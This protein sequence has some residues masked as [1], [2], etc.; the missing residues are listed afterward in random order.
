MTTAQTGPLSASDALDGAQF[1]PGAV[2]AGR[3]RIVGL[4][5]H[6]G[7]GDVYRADDLKLGQA[8]ALK[9]LPIELTSRPDR[10]A[11]FHT[12]VRLARQVSHPNVC[13]VHDIGDFS[14]QHFLSMEYI[15][16]EDLASLLRR[17]GRLPPDKAIELAHQLCAGLAAAHERRVLHRDLKPA[18]V[19]IDGQGRAHLADF[20]LAMLAGERRQEAEIAGTPGYMAPEQLE[21]REVSARTDVYALGLVLYEMFTG[22]RALTADAVGPSRKGMPV[23]PVALDLPDVDPA[24]EHVILRCLER[25]PGRR[26]A[27][28]AAVAA[29]LPGRS[30]LAAAVATGETPSPDAVAAAG[31]AGTLSPAVGALCFGGV[32]AG[33]LLLAVGAARDVSLIGLTRPE[34]GPQFFVERAHT[35][36]RNLGYVEPAGDEAAGYAV[37]L[38]YLQYIDAHDRSSTRWRT[39]ATTPPSA[40]LFWYRQNSRRLVPL[41]G[42]IIVTRVNPPPTGPGAVSLSL[43][44]AGRLVSLLI[45]P[46][47]GDESQRPLAGNTPAWVPLFEQAGLPLAQF[48]S[49]ASQWIPPVYADARAAWSGAYPERPDIPIRVE[50]AAALGR[51]VFFEIVAPWS[52]PPTDAA[53]AR[54]TPGE[55]TGRFMRLVVGPVALAIAVVLALRNLRLGRG[56]RRGAMRVSLFIGAVTAASIA[57]ATGD[58]QV[59]SKGPPIV[60]FVPAAVWLL[61][62]ALEPHFRR[63]WP[64]IMIGWSRLLAGRVRDPLVGRDVLVGVLAGIGDALTLAFHAQLRR[65]MGAPPPFPVGA[66]NDPFVGAA[67]SSDLLLGGRFALSRLV[68]SVVTIPVLVWTLLMFLLLFVLFLIVR[69]RS[70]AVTAMVLCLTVFYAVVHTGWLLAYAPDDLVPPSFSDIVFFAVI[71]S[72][73]VIVAVR[74]GLLTMLVAAFVSIWLTPLPLTIDASVPYASASSLVVVAV[75]ALAF[76]GWHTALAGR[77]MFGAGFLADEPARRA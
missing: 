19:L 37:D 67:A 23:A 5:G 20:G 49:V 68:G 61:Y 8:V 17:I 74:F 75:I 32:L 63:I 2:L 50:A 24:V 44:Q 70:V 51:P 60:F 6:G 16:G 31:E 53:E 77:L 14:G 33:L 1:I 59:L 27:S 48:A 57:L 42:A 40:L 25:D 47:Q 71:H 21:G 22:R 30:L 10:L 29:S 66:S 3:Y 65:W 39:L 43:D 76:Y 28:V 13:R 45:V 18:N 73:I 64:G 56:D 4:L 35:V 41:G 26:P 54:A 55:R 36:L 62:I 11:R 12:E 52:P 58:L 72:A 7:M 69:R 38:D 46:P 34:H 15:D 9:F